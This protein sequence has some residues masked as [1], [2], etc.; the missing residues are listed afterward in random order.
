MVVLTRHTVRRLL[1]EAGFRPVRTWTL[2]GSHA[3]FALSLRLWLEARVPQRRVRA[4]IVRAV[5]H[6]LTRLLALPYFWITDRLG[7]GSQLTVL[8]EPVGD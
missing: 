8:A 6:P 7:L 5:Y 3:S 1:A 2:S 4:A